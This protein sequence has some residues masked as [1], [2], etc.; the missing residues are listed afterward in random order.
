MNQYTLGSTI[1]HLIEMWVSIPFIIYETE[2]YL[3]PL[4]LKLMMTM[5]MNTEQPLM[6]MLSPFQPIGIH[7]EP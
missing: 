1:L 2:S 7:I 6:G 5:G 4:T 3:T